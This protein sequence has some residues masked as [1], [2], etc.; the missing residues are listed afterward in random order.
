M[1]AEIAKFIEYNRD[2][3]VKKEELTKKILVSTLDQKT[4]QIF[5]KNINFLYNNKELSNYGAS[6]RKQCKTNGIIKFLVVENAN[7]NQSREK[8]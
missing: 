4:K 8:L 3:G 1:Y 6:L 7:D 2:N 5:L